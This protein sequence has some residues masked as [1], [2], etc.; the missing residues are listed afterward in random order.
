MFII[1]LYTCI[2]GPF[3]SV[4]LFHLKNNCFLRTN[5]KADTFN[6]PGCHTLFKRLI[7]N[8][9]TAVYFMVIG[10]ILMV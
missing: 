1:L 8:L 5:F 6:I 9:S 3:F 2:F 4:M 7:N 10:Q